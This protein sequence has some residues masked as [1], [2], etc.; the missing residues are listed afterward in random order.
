[1]GMSEFKN[2]CFNCGHNFKHD[3]TLFYSDCRDMFDLCPCCIT[4]FHMRI[5]DRIRSGRSDDINT[6]WIKARK[7]CQEING[8]YERRKY[9][10]RFRPHGKDKLQKSKNLKAILE[11]PL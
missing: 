9:P 3:V 4:P 1:M 10:T 7:K 2:A 11:K 5:L 6:A 8:K